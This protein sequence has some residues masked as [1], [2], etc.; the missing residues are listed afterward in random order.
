MLPPRIIWNCALIAAGTL[1]LVM[2]LFDG[3]E[4]PVFAAGF[5]VLAGF[6]VVHSHRR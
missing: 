6:E 5:V 2:V 3:I 1:Y 4:S